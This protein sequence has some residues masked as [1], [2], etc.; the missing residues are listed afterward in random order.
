MYN[1]F[2]TYQTNDRREC[3]CGMASMQRPQDN[4]SD[5]PAAMAYVPCNISHRSMNCLWLYR[6]ELYFLN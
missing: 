4:C 3:P 1:N 6:Q 5:L 2:N